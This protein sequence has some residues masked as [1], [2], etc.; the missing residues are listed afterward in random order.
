M[1]ETI[2]S[3]NIKLR[4][5]LPEDETF[6]VAV[7]G[8][9]REQELA[10]V[11]WTAEQKEA[12]LRFQLTAQLRHY[13]TEYP[14]AEFSIILF[15]TEPVGLFETEPV[16]LFE[17]EPVG[18]LYVDRRETEF[19]IM[20]ITLLPAHRGKRISSPIINRLKNE[21]ATVGKNLSINLDKLSQSH[22]VFEHLGFKAT[23]DTGFHVL[24][25]WKPAEDQSG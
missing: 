21:A 11:P 18:R 22:S 16:G 13:Q 3:P 1:T 12:F 19:R 6:L 4:P 9:T 24:Y 14:N 25:V 5:Q 8:S 10:M 7:Y 2:I 20:D 15:E 17:T 23:E